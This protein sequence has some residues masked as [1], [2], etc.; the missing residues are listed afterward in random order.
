MR[1]ERDLELALF[2][3][4]NTARLS[5]FPPKQRP[6]LAKELSRL[7]PQAPKPKQ[8]SEQM[9]AAM[10]AIRATMGG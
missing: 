7:K 6:S 9:I 1:A 3:A 5:D 4:W 8:T 10:R 2:T